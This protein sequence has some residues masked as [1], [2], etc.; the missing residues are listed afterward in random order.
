MQEG[1]GQ[2]RKLRASSSHPDAP[3]KKSMASDVAVP[4]MRKKEKKMI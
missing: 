4:S 3:D 1:Q 2:G